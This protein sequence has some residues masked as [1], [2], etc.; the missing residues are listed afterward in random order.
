MRAEV[1]VLQL[2]RTV[3]RAF[4]EQF[5]Q[6]CG[7]E[8]VEAAEDTLHA[9]SAQGKPLRMVLTAIGLLFDL[10][11]L[12]IAER[13]RDAVRD[14]RHA[15]RILAR[16]PGFTLSAVFSLSAGIGVTAAMYSQ[17]HSTI[18]RDV[19]GVGESAGLVRLQK[20]VC[21]DDYD[22]MRVRGNQFSSVAAFLGP[23]PLVT[24][25]A[26]ERP[27][28]LWGHIV[29]PNY[30]SVLGARAARGRLFGV[31]EE[32]PGAGQVVV[33]GHGLWQS[34]FGGDP[35]VVGRSI[36][37]NGQPAIVVGVAEP[38]FAGAAP[39][40]A[41]AELWIPTTAPARTAPELQSL[42]DRRSANFNV[43]G[44]LAPGVTGAD[45]E[46]SLEAMVRRLER[47]HNDPGKDS[48]ER[49]I[50]LLPG[51]RMF[52]VREADLP[53]AI[54][55]PLLL[56]G[57]VLLMA[58][59]NVANMML[60]RT[61]TRR[62]EL[63]VRLSLGAGPGRITRQMLTESL[64]LSGLGAVGGL[65]FASWFNWLAGSI[66]PMIPS[67]ASFETRLLWQPLVIAAVLAGSSVFLFGVA[68][69]LR[70]CRADVFSG[71]KMR[72]GVDPAGRRWFNWRNLLVFQQVAISMVLLLLTSFIVVGWRRSAKVDVGYDPANLYLV[73]LDP[74]RNGYSA[75]QATE[76]FRGLLSRL[77]GANGVASA[78]LAQSL[79]L[80]MSGGDLM[81]NAK[82]EFAGSARSFGSMRADRIGSGFFRTLGAPVRHG[83]EFSEA[84]L[85]NE[86]RVLIVNET[87]A[88]QFWPGANPVGQ[89]VEFE[90]EKW[91]VIGVASDIRSA[92]PLA[93][94]VAAVFRPAAPSG[95]GNPGLHGVTFLIRTEPGIDASA[96]FR[97]ALDAVDPRATLFQLR[98][99][100]A[101]LDQMTYLTTFATFVYGGMGLF[102]LLL[103]S[104]GL[105]GVTAFAVARRSH[106][107]GIRVA[108]GA[109]R[110]KV[111]SLVLKEGGVI[112]LAGTVIGLAIALA[113]TRAL[114][115]FVETLGRATST[116]LT[117]PLLLIGVPAALAC[118]ALGACLLPA[119]RAI[120]IDPAVALRSE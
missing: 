1:A 88:R 2:Y 82:V 20:P 106:E 40:T 113:V 41:S 61:M 3:A 101:E 118:L 9:E 42:R 100:S 36:E 35:G 53:K 95:F 33:L 31:D 109:N 112:L 60:A 37:V 10:L 98:P 6:I 54:G 49:R 24:G 119:A 99:A 7:P 46:Q 18:F 79:P 75:E 86:A 93:L 56:A 78:S 43:I 71:L 59:G 51:G 64:L 70:S 76:L 80:A 25:R 81:V 104:V 47:I 50:R 91:Q 69:A 90:G 115:S 27:Q 17:I 29:T 77:R 12:L 5:E 8:M 58:C 30:F 23:V 48:Q 67:Y 111:L 74:V 22:E 13:C 108:L 16:S 97:E 87:M 45:A 15:A 11:V 117:D 14:T 89:I 85:R 57:L 94:A 55:F 105:A 103:A 32:R 34:R 62:K 92:F 38:G 21:Y 63:A 28:R 114:A 68:P 72:T 65:S 107:I 4:P 116:S 52:P 120:R 110:A 84:D 96:T 66:R 73:G 83:R 102:G 39:T 19:P 26:G 44:R